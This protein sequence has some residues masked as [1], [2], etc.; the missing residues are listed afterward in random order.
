MSPSALSIVS[1]FTTG[2][3]GGEDRR[4]R[5]RP[6][7]GFLGAAFLP[8]GVSAF[9]CFDSAP[10]LIPRRS[11]PRRVRPLPQ[12]RLPARAQP[13]GSACGNDV[14]V[15]GSKFFTRLG[16]PPFFFLGNQIVLLL[17]ISKSKAAA[18]KTNAVFPA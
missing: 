8:P 10:E 14:R 5:G 16:G 12:G 4:V 7:P 9:G 3:G 11:S 15:G 18:G 2:S 13:P 1:A 17:L 6:S